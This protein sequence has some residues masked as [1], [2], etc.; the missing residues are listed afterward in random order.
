MHVFIPK[1]G[2]SV[3]FNP[4]IQEN[5]N[6]QDIPLE[7]V[8]IC[9]FTSLPNEPTFAMFRLHIRHL[10]NIL[11]WMEPTKIRVQ[12]WATQDHPKTKLYVSECCSNASW[13][14]TAWSHVHCSGEPVSGPPHS[15]E[16][17]LPNTQ[18]DPPVISF[19]LLAKNPFL[20]PGKNVAAYILMYVPLSPGKPI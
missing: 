1:N 14:V 7:A 18:T 17:P 10:R 8:S 12:L 13:I 2:V 19:E 9:H 5:Q 6:T 16:K 11:S 20:C 15:G 4:V 3:T